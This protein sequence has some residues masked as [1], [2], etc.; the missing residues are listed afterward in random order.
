[1]IGDKSNYVNSDPEQ[2]MEMGDEFSVSSEEG[3]PS[4]SDPSSSETLAKGETRV[5]RLLRGVVLT[6]LLL[7]AAG[8][9]FAVFRYTSN[10]EQQEFQNS[11]D[12]SA[13]KVIE[14][15]KVN[16]AGQL[17][18]VDNFADAISATA[19]ENNETWPMVTVP[20]YSLLARSALSST[21][22]LSILIHPVVNQEERA[23]WNKYA[24]EHNAEWKEQDLALQAQGF[25]NKKLSQKHNTTRRNLQETD[26]SEYDLVGIENGM[27]TDIY[28][29]VW[30][31]GEENP[32]MVRSPAER[33]IFFP[34]WQNV[35]AIP[36]FPENGES[37][38]ASFYPTIR[39]EHKALT[40]ASYNTEGGIGA[41]L[42][43][44]DGHLA[45]WGR[46]DEA[47][48]SDPLGCIFYPVHEDF[49][50][51]ATKVVAIIAMFI[52]WRQ[53]FVDI[54][55]PDAIGVYAV[56]ENNCDQRFTFVINGKD[57]VYL[58]EH[59][60]HD[61][62]YNEYMHFVDM[63]D[64]FNADIS[65][66]YYGVPL[67]KESG[68]SYTLSVYPSKEFED[69]FVT[70]TPMIYAGAVV[71]IFLFAAAIFLLYDCAVEL[72][73]RLVMRNALRSGAIVSSMFP[74]EIQERMMQE[75][76]DGNKTKRN[77]N[78]YMSSTKRVKSF[79]NG[80]GGDDEDCIVDSKPIA[81][82]FPETTVMVSF[83][84]E[85]IHRLFKGYMTH[86][87]SLTT[88][89]FPQ[90]SDIE[91]FTAWSSQRDPAQV[92]TLLQSIYQ[93]FDKIAKRMK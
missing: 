64:S 11:F 50:N 60:L 45:T 31:P 80:E 72:R 17:T 76:E 66:L 77:K 82:L 91:N 92:F 71:L 84:K 83:V 68:C 30:V 22:A 46:E 43:V 8:V 3:E 29:T 67:S 2:A 12:D 27:A 51:D 33:E 48:G 47:I 58:D 62:S 63:V 34:V 28:D 19:K 6:V 70:S 85:E 65:P 20:N 39:L 56:F 89:A 7:T 44:T 54:L 52:H 59:D 93:A 49:G 4:N 73:Q 81:D 16:T 23:E 15:L 55:P 86:N 25:Y 13:K 90:F 42:S 9:S 24:L 1:M 18:A 32:L 53:L 41:G 37:P 40:G 78:A 14:S 87:T 79:L 21:K 88:L 35:P 61:P 69:Q 36:W 74:K 57:V 10:Q 75:Q 26:V 5:V 38:W